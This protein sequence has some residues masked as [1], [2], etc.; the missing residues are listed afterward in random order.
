MQLEFLVEEPSAEAALGILV[1]RIIGAEHTARF[2][3][4]QG[5]QDLLGKLPARL[6]A[7]REWLPADAGIVV[8]V[9]EDRED[10]GELKGL[11]ERHA[12]AAGF[13]T[14][15]SVRRG[16][17]FEVLNRIAIEE[18]EAWFFGDICAL[19]EAYPGIPVSLG[20][21][22]KYRLPDRIRGGTWEALERVLRVAGHHRGGLQKVRAARDIGTHMDPWRNQSPSFRAFRDGLLALVSR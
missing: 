18:L 6:G 5:K 20:K 1:P 4:H 15:T 19:V 13:T 16:A 9:D 8:V 10:C 3:P 14:R 7:Y 17:R 12:Q 2:H 22:A 21:R 11:L